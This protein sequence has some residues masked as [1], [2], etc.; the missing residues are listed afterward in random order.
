M[1]Q[2]TNART[3]RSRGMQCQIGRRKV[4]G[5]KIQASSSPDDEPNFYIMPFIG[6]MSNYPTSCQT[7][8]PAIEN[9]H[10][11]MLR[12][13]AGRNLPSSLSR[14][15]SQNS[16]VTEGASNGNGSRQFADSLPNHNA[17]LRSLQNPLHQNALS[18]DLMRQQALN[19]M[20]YPGYQR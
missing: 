16:N 15:Q 7:M 19:C 17:G 10:N 3:R 5:T 8:S 11:Q 18:F 13:A 1:R 6:L 2:N 12:A 20:Q 9:H 4:K 14:L